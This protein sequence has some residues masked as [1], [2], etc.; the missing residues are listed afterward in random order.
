MITYLPC[1][2]F[3]FPYQ[4][5]GRAGPHFYFVTFL[6]L[7]LT[8]THLVKASVLLYPNLMVISSLSRTSPGPEITLLLHV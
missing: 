6:S 7:L 3:P 2:F 1:H 4:I 5:L 8:E